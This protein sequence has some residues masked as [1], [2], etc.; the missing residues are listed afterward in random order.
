VIAFGGLIIPFAALRRLS[1]SIYATFALVALGWLFFMAQDDL[2]SRLTRE[3]QITAFLSL[4][5]LLLLMGEIA[6][7]LDMAIREATL[8]REAAE[9]ANLAKSEF[10]A[11]MSHDLRTPLNVV[12][13]YSEVITD[14]VLGG[15]EAWPRYR[16]YANDI[17]Q[18]GEF[19]LA[20]VD[21]IL[22]IARI[23]SG[24]VTLRL[25]EVDIA[26]VVAETVSRLARIAERDG[27]TLV[28]AK[29]GEVAPIEAD[30]R[31]IEQIMQ[32]LVSNAIKFTPTGK[33]AGVRIASTE[34]AVVI[35]VWDEGIG[36]AEA[37]IPHLG[38]PFRRIGRPDVAE[39]PGTGLGVAIVK[40]LVGLHG[41]TIAF[42][43]SVDVGTTI[44][45]TLPAKAPG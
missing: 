15:Y 38:E 4:A 41:G 32:N 28:M 40:N 23:E 42:S 11:R 29:V 33:H 22:D 19:L 37:E 31:A 35:E 27:I 7:N 2:L 39:K 10:L 36:I 9:R 26:N 43:S 45:V 17:R 25:E 14:E 12:I 24:G 44:R 30:R 3:L 1:W 5:A 8:A 20:I 16:E 13:G 18:S 34:D 6:S 21:D